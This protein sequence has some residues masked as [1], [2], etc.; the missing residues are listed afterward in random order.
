MATV[1]ASQTE[2]SVFSS[3]SQAHDDGSAMLNAREFVR[4]RWLVMGLILAATLFA[5]AG[6]LRVIAPRYSAHAEILL[7]PQREK[8]VGPDNSAHL[9]SLDSSDLESAVAL[10]EGRS[11]LDRVAASQ[12]LD[13][14][15]EFAEGNRS[16]ALPSVSRTTDA[17]GQSRSLSQTDPAA[18]LKGSLK[19]ERVGKAYVL[20]IRVTSLDPSKASRLANAV[21]EAFVS[22]Q[23]QAH[24]EAGRRLAAYF[25]ERLEPLGERLRRSEDAL[26]RFR[27][28]HGLLARSASAAH[29]ANTT[30]NEQQLSELNSRLVAAQAETAQAWAR[31]SQ[32]RSVQAQGAT[33]D[34]IPD[35]V[36]ST[37]IALLRQQQAE[38]ARKE[39]DLAARYADSF[40]L[41]VNARAERR[42]IERSIAREI[43]RIVANLQGAYD[44]A[45]SQEDALRAGLTVTTGA[46]GLD[47]DLGARLRELERLKLVDETMFETYL[48]KART[49]EQQATYEDRDVRVISP[50][51]VPSIPAYPK[52]SLAAGCMAVFGLGLGIALGLLLDAFEAGFRSS[53]DTETELGLPV[54]AA[55]PWLD[56]RER[57]VEGRLV[58]PSRY[59]ANRPH[60]RYAEAVHAIRAGVR[61]SGRSAAQV[62]LVTSSVAGEGKSVLALS[63]ALSAARAG[64]RVLLL[65]ADLRAPSLSIYFGAQHRLGLVDLLTGLVGTDETTVALGGGLSIMPA[66]RRSAVAPDLFASPRMAHYL[67]HLRAVYDL[68][69]IDAA[70]V[71]VVVDARVLAGLSDRVVFVVGWR[72]TA[73]AE[74]SR[75]LRMLQPDKLAGIVLN[76]TDERRLPYGIGRRRPITRRAEA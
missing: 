30:I 11:L 1:A 25:A 70:P 39:A 43:G 34:T 21:A 47:S 28:E 18:A 3:R 66:G 64:Q 72:A 33:L 4:R 67:A 38:V 14:D 22:D 65:D 32:A 12:H 63:V 42:G 13:A 26:D 60:S 50:A 71:G 48:A 27:R 54:L 69:V 56:N 37:L 31:Y 74:V 57:I 7:E 45:K 61:M 68:V 44:V 6:V 41:L 5:T 52:R 76:K 62:V 51:E 10:I 53:R 24:L 9:V 59:L 2:P 40:P 73:R 55:V 75:N 49:A 29:D 19:V 8:S 20:S 17:P 35:V 16:A 58:D 46:A 15:P 23:R 36:R